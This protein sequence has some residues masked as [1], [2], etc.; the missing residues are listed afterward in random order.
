M[1]NL[2]EAVGY[3]NQKHE[4]RAPLSVNACLLLRQLGYQPHQITRFYGFVAEIVSYPFPSPYGASIKVQE[5]GEPTTV[6]EAVV[7][8]TALE[9]AEKE[10]ELT[11]CSVCQKPMDAFVV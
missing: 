3:W 4:S 6:I 8:P 10:I 7:N 2:P 5:P 9:F 1:T 11:K